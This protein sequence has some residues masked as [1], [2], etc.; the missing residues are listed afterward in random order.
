MITFAAK[1]EA[2]E[3]GNRQNKILMS[4]FFAMNDLYIINPTSIDFLLD[5]I[6]IKRSHVAHP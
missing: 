6:Y 3:L 1:H 4:D 5:W 2:K